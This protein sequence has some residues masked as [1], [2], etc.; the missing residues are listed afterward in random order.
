MVNTIAGGGAPIELLLVEDSLGDIRLTREALTEA[1]R[2]IHLHVAHDGVEAMAF[3]RHEGDQI[4]AP[5]PDL[6]LLDLNLPK[7]N[8]HQVLAQIKADDSLKR[9]PIIVLTTSDADA[10]VMKSYDLQANCYLTKPVDLDK[11]ENLVK[12]F[13]QFWLTMAKLPHEDQ[14]G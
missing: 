6:I 10:D 2:A 9:I 14:R 1:K 12:S 13:N 8:G 7:M 4:H 3:L 5:R 11:F